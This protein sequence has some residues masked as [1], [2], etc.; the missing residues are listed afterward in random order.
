MKLIFSLILTFAA[1]PAFAQGESYAGSSM[2][3]G[4]H[5]LYKATVPY[6]IGFEKQIAAAKFDRVD[7][8]ITGDRFSDDPGCDQ[9]FAREFALVHLDRL[10]TPAQ[11]ID[12]MHRRGF[13]P[14]TLLELA[15]FAAKHPDFQRDFPIVALRNGWKHPDGVKRYGI[16]H[17]AKGRRVLDLERGDRRYVMNVRFLAVRERR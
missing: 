1:A 12:T 6:S 5:G 3:M 9:D 15:A 2:T 7:P 4:G 13:R 14:A 10:A 17:E 11:A 8:T 16:I